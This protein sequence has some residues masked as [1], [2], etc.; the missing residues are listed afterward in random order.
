[1]QE[2]VSYNLAAFTKNTSPCQLKMKDMICLF[3]SPTKLNR[4][5]F[6]FAFSISRQSFKD[7]V[8]VWQ[9]NN[10][11]NLVFR[12]LVKN[13]CLSFSSA[14]WLYEYIQYSCSCSKR[15]YVYHRKYQMLHLMIKIHHLKYHFKT[16]IP[17]SK[18]Y[19]Y[20]I[21]QIPI[22]KAIFCCCQFTHF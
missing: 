22:T 10:S 8:R 2:Q 5:I 19:F 1:M 13:G 9:I 18:P 7:H 15:Y 12:V 6:L 17:T 20:E 3:F 21:H 4:I 11:T 14:S 16:S